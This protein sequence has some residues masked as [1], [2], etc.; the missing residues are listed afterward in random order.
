VSR[1]PNWYSEELFYQDLYGENQ[2][3]GEEHEE[4]TPGQNYPEITEY[5]DE[6]Q[7]ATHP[8]TNVNHTPQQYEDG[9]AMSAQNFQLVTYKKNQT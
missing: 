8:K 1:R 4:D 6:E 3:Q 9:D 2:H 7:V 5:H